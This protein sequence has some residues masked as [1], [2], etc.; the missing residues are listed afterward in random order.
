ME[1]PIGR[2]SIQLGIRG[3]AVKKYVN[4]WIVKIT[5]ITDDV[6]RIKKSIDNGTFKENLLPEEKEY[7]I[8]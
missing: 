2:R 4:E 5:D 8:K 6:K 1:K 3:A 7:I